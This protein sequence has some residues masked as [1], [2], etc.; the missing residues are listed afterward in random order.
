MGMHPVAFDDCEVE[1]LWDCVAAF[2][3]VTLTDSDPPETIELPAGFETGFR[4]LCGLK[5]EC[6]SEI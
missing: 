2:R 6:H 1:A 4:K 5:A 3:D